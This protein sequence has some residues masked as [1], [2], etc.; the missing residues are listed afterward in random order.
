LDHHHKFS[1]HSPAVKN[2]D[3]LKRDKS[4]WIRVTRH[5]GT[6]AYSAVERSEVWSCCASAVHGSDGCD[7]SY[8]NPDAWDLTSMP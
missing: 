2:T 5:T 4:S 7:V 8:K 3:S 6:W 1:A